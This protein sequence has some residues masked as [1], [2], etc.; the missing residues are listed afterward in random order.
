MQRTSPVMSVLG[1]AVLAGPFW[2]ISGLLLETRDKE[3]SPSLLLGVNKV[4]WGLSSSQTG[5][6]ETPSKAD[7]KGER[8]RVLARVPSSPIRPLTKWAPAP[9]SPATGLDLAPCLLF[10][11][12]SPPESQRWHSSRSGNCLDRSGRDCPRSWW[13]FG[14]ENCRSPWDLCFLL[15]SLL[16]SVNFYFYNTE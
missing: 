13:F 2:A 15:L 4:S 9:V 11:R 12:R 14:C 1:I 10:S 6:K 8:R 16:H 7:R 3:Q 5:Q